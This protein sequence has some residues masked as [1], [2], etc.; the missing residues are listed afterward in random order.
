MTGALFREAAESDGGLGAAAG[1]AL[2]EA[3]AGDAGGTAGRFRVRVIRAGTSG[4]GNHYPDATLRAAVPLFD[5]ARVFAKSDADHLAGRGKDVR[6]LIGALT[7]PV[8][9]EGAAPEGGAVEATLTLIDPADPIG[10]KLREAVARGMA[11]LFGLSIDATGRARAGRAGGRAVRIA[12]A[13]TQVHSVDLIVEPGAGGRFLS[14]IE[15]RRPERLGPENPEGD[16]EVRSRLIEAIRRLRPALLAGKDA[17]TLNDDELEALFSEALAPADPPPPPPPPAPPHATAP[18]NAAADTAALVQA[19]VARLAEA[20]RARDVRLTAMRQR[21]AASRLPERARARIVAEFEAAADAFTEAQV[22]ARIQGEADY[23]APFVAGGR[24]AGLGTAALVESMEDR[25]AK[26]AGMLDAFFDPAHADHR[27]AQ[28][29]RECY[30]EIT[31]D[32]RVTGQRRDC[33]EARLREALGSDSFDAVLGDALHR[34]LIADYRGQVDLDLWKLLTGAPTRATDFR[35]QTR[36]RYGGYGDLPKVTERQPYLELTSP[37]DDDPVTFAVEKRGG[38]ESISIEMIRN[39]DVG[40]V[41]A[42][43]VKM[44]RAAKRTLAKFVLDFIRLNPSI[45]DGK[46]LFHV[47]H[48]NLGTAALDAAGY[49]A[50]RLAMVK[51]TEY[52]QSGERIGVGPKYLWVPAELEE[53]AFNIFQRSTNND[54]TFVQTLVPTIVPVW[55]WTDANDWALSVDPLDI[56]TIELAFLDSEEPELFVQDSPS[57]GSLF[58]NDTLTYKI[59]HIYGGNVLDHRGLRK[60]VVP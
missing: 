16:A 41:R 52:G 33:D 32:A 21:V 6:N 40:A 4:N 27:S 22:D 46:A 24:V 44:G 39:D 34:R 57:S 58:A 49:A 3:L 47:D 45:Y 14:M 1:G 59:R 8:F 37:T 56:P 31:G 28:S 12:E 15:S 20:M 30:R 11:G 51:Q 29:F 48:G 42:V 13:I 10:T 9:V 26:V 38:T 53:A 19:E 50:A 5:G 36:T 23:L 17:G 43:P 54:K 25:R 55:Y 18:Q 2:L 35:L 7:A 60:H